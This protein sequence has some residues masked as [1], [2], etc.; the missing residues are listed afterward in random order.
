VEFVTPLSNDED[1]VDAYHDDKPLHYRTMDNI[2]GDQLVPG[3]AMH[4]F[5]GGAA[6]SARRRRAPL[7]R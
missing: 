6:P 2:L 7:L 1:H 4:N 5:K 3:L